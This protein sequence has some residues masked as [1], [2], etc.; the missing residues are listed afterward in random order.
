[1]ISTILKTILVL[2]YH[3]LI[4]LCFAIV[5]WI[6]SLVITQYFRPKK[7]KRDLD[8]NIIKGKKDHAPWQLNKHIMFL[9]WGTI[10]I[11]LWI[12]LNG[13]YFFGYD[14]CVWGYRRLC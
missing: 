11:F 8:G 6:I 1:M 12:R 4:S 7:I 10:F 13:G 5:I 2:I 14:T 3:L 9:F